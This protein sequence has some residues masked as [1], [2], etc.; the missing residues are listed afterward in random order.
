LNKVFEQYEE[1]H[2]SIL[3]QGAAGMSTQIRISADALEMVASD[4]TDK[5]R[6]FIAKTNTPT[7][8]P[9]MVKATDGHRPMFDSKG[10]NPNPPFM[11][12]QYRK[13][14][15]RVVWLKK[16]E[17]QILFCQNPNRQDGRDRF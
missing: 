11:L 8:Q 16:Y 13:A 10:Q 3:T 1:R 9:W 17:R 15:H 5:L 2:D 7:D 4:G 6:N 14:K 12:E